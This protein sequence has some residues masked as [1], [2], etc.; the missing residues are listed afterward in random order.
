[1]LG[2]ETS[3]AIGDRIATIAMNRP[4]SLNAIRPDMYQALSELWIE[5]RGNHKTT[6]FSIADLKSGS[7]LWQR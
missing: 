4:E 6:S 3:I 5:V 7:R 2:L 1:M